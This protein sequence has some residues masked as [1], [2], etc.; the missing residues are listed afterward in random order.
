MITITVSKGENEI[1]RDYSEDADFTGVIEDMIETLDG[2][3]RAYN[4]IEEEYISKMEKLQ[5][6][7]TDTI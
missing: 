1:Y 2:S 7:E 4:E 6:I 5:D 3:D